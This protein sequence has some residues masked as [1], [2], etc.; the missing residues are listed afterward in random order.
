MV[1]QTHF[2]SEACHYKIAGREPCVNLVL[3]CGKEDSR[4]NASTNDL[5]EWTLTL[6]G[7][8]DRDDSTNVHQ[9]L[10]ELDKSRD[11]RLLDFGDLYFSLQNAIKDR[12][13]NRPIVRAL[14][15]AINWGRRSCS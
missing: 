1:L 2:G 9:V 12:V 7:D 5:E 14:V 11:R 10:A 8:I 3:G 15:V 13:G 4:E 6:A